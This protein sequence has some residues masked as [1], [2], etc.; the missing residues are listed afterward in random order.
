[1]LVTK[2]FKRS[3][4]ATLELLGS[5]NSNSE[6]FVDSDGESWAV[7]MDA[8]ENLEDVEIT[9]LAENYCSDKN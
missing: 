4:K 6:N 9:V 7:N 8:A 2:L 5:E 1:M 3:S